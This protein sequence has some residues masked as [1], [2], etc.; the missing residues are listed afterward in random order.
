MR[1]LRQSLL[2]GSASPATWCGPWG[3]AREALGTVRFSLSRYT[4]EAEIQWVA[5][6]VPAL[7]A[8][9]RAGGALARR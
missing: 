8:E 9:L 3:G 2:R 1:L 5:E 4:T 6:R 7:V